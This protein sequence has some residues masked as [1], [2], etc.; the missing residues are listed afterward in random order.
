MI[1]RFGNKIK[2]PTGKDADPAYLKAEIKFIWKG[3]QK[4]PTDVKAELLSVKGER[5]AVRLN[6]SLTVRSDLALLEELITALAA[7]CV[8]TKNRNISWYMAWLCRDLYATKSITSVHSTSGMDY[9]AMSC[10]FFEYYEKVEPTNQGRNLLVNTYCACAARLLEAK[11]PEKDQQ[12]LEFLEKARACEQKIAPEYSRNSRYNISE[13]L[14][15]RL[16]HVYTRME[17]WQESY[18]A[19]LMA[20]HYAW[21]KVEQTK[22]RLSVNNLSNRCYQ[23]ITHLLYDREADPIRLAEAVALLE[24]FYGKNP[25]LTKPLSY[26]GLKK[27]LSES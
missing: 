26:R 1:D 11:D 18:D 5:L 22:D 7:H 15:D 16:C 19:L 9:L 25:L 6:K 8:H 17:K 20:V 2:P 23:C 14:Y 24:D 12:A 10:Y 13:A 27:Y 4:D 3:Y 21:K